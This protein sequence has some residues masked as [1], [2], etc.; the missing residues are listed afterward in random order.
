MSSF[1]IIQ[2]QTVPTTRRK[3]RTRPNPTTSPAG[4]VALLWSSATATEVSACAPRPS[5][6][7]KSGSGK[8]SF[9]EF[10]LSIIWFHQVLLDWWRNVTKKSEE[11]VSSPSLSALLRRERFR[12]EHEETEKTETFQGPLG[13]LKMRT[14]A[15]SLVGTCRGRKPHPALAHIALFPPLPHVQ[16]HGSGLSRPDEFNNRSSRREEAQIRRSEWLIR[17][18]LEWI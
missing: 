4:L 7:W 5:A 2:A 12:R 17:E 8:Q 11:K 13:W 14:A 6:N 10:M 9:I 18:S 1:T 3:E 15:H 16:L